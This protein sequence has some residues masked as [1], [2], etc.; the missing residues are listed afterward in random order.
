MSEC[1]KTQNENENYYYFQQY[2]QSFS[3]K[4]ISLKLSLPKFT[5]K[6]LIMTYFFTR[7]TSGKP[8]PGSLSTIVRPGLKLFMII[9]YWWFYQT[10]GIKYPDEGW[11]RHGVCLL[12]KDNFYYDKWL[13]WLAVSI[14][15]L[16]LEISR[17]SNTRWGQGASSIKILDFIHYYR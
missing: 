10:E 13:A 6:L 5:L 16:W 14:F 11:T 8:Q 7:S 9:N 4:K 17:S 1:A 2:D 12:L 3:K 15:T